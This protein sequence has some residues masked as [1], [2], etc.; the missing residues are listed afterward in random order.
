MIDDS[1]KILNLIRRFSLARFKSYTCSHDLAVLSLYSEADEPDFMRYELRFILCISIQALP[2]ARLT[3]TT[4]G[5]H[6]GVVEF[7]SGRICI[8]CTEIAVYDTEPQHTCFYREIP[9]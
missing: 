6:D 5:I 4:I 7:R 8:S 2:I 1:D 3:E 9:S